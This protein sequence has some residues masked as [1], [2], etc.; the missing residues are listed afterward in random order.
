[1]LN[2][3]GLRS[4]YRE[5]REERV[6]SVYVDGAQSDPA[7]RRA[8]R[9]RLDRGLA[10]ERRRV[11]E[12]GRD[13]VEQF[14]AARQ[15]IETALS[16]FTDFLPDRGWVGFATP[17]RLRHGGGVPV[18]MPDQVRWEDGIRVAPYV[19]ALKQERTV[20]AVVADRRR[21]RLFTYR[22]GEVTEHEPMT[23]DTD[24]GDLADSSTSKRGSPT[25]GTRGETGTDAGQRATEVS[26]ERLHARVVQ[27]L[28]ELAGH[29]GFLVLGGTTEAVKALADEAGAFE[30][31]LIERPSMHMDLTEAEAMAEIESAAS[32]LTRG[33]QSE[34]LEAVVDAARSGGKGCLGIQAT[35]EALREGRVDLLFLTRGMRE[36]E[37]DLA[38]RFVGTAFERA[39]YVEE[40]SGESAERLDAEG[41]G[42]GARLRYTT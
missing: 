39:A 38:D 36:R 5:L 21:A 10:E 3:D 40:L 35:K 22:A 30:G 4:L 29:E 9:V 25:S 15:E 34:L 32:E 8:W 16:D 27:R 18:P 17:G 20:A 24:F 6:L 11:E 33:M 7:E 37:G 2:H 42:V 13:A 23:A 41:E 12:L 31:R 19:R 14:D 26:A 28:G 1:M